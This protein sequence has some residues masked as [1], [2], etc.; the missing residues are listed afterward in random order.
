MASTS[1]S[2]RRRWRAIDPQ[3]SARRRQWSTVYPSRA[4][5]A[6]AIASTDAPSVARRSSARRCERTVSA[7]CDATV[8][9]VRSSVSPRGDRLRDSI[10]STPTGRRPAS[11][12]T[13]TARPAMPG[14]PGIWPSSRRRRR[15]P[16]VEVAMAR[17]TAASSPRGSQSTRAPSSR[18]SG[19]ARSS[20]TAC[21]ST[22]RP[23]RLRPISRPSVLS[24]YAADSPISWSATSDSSRSRRRRPSRRR[25]RSRPAAY[26][27]ASWS[28][29]SA[30]ESRSACWISAA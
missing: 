27:P 18:P 9:M 21:A 16:S 11:S 30:G 19:V 14:R 8:A 1:A 26:W 3:K 12:G 22:M 29:S 25:T 4:S 15:A 28:T 23:S 17:S 7:S 10:T 2:G 24:A 5:T 6:P 13:Y 20:A